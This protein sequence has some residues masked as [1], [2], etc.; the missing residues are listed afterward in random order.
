MVQFANS[1]YLKIYDNEFTNVGD[2]DI[3]IEPEYV[4]GD[5]NMEGKPINI[6]DIWIYKTSLES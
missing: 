5:G 6:S 3:D 4:T 1:R 2:S